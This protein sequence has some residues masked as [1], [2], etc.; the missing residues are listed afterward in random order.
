MYWSILSQPASPWFARGGR[1]GGLVSTLD[2]PIGSIARAIAG[3]VVGSVHLAANTESHHWNVRT[4][5]P[6]SH[7]PSCARRSARHARIMPSSETWPSLLALSIVPS[8]PPSLPPS[9]A[10]LWTECHES[11]LL[12]LSFAPSSSF[13]PSLPRGRPSGRE[14]RRS[15]TRSSGSRAPRCRPTPRCRSGGAT[16]ARCSRATSAAASA[17]RTRRAQYYYWSNVGA[18]GARSSF[19]L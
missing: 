9:R 3:A 4:E 7:P 1:R 15:P 2:V 18:T 13:S 8:L 17:R 19:G 10:A 12:T 16:P 5:E 6:P 14:A 11:S